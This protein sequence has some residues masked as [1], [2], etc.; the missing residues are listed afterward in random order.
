[1][2]CTMK[3]NK[4]EQYLQQ[5]DAFESPKIK[6][7]QYMTPP[8]IAACML[9]T[10]QSSYNDVEGKM[11]ADLGCGTGMLSIA[12]LLLGADF[13]IGFDIDSDAL[14][15]YN[16]N[17]EEF[18]F[19]LY[20]LV[21][22]NVSSIDEKFHKKFDTVILNPPFGTNNKGIDIEFLKT[23]INLARNSVYSLHKTSTREHVLS[24]ACRWNVKSKVI[25]ELRFDLPHSYKFHTKKSVD[26]AIDLHRL[27][28]L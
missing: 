19:T 1:M 20:D 11:I 6:L 27:W 12:S 25:A 18:E 4:L 3:L 26:I 22:C 10:I 7:E 16:A 5:V 28:D 8:H 21:S 24:K 2:A 15:T 13:C 23:A 9:H 14:S 17:M